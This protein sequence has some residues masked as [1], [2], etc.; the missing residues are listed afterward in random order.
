MTQLPLPQEVK[1]VYIA[2]KMSGLPLWNFPAFEEAAKN[3]RGRGLEVFSPAEH[4]LEMGFEPTRETF[5]AKERAESMHWDFETIFNVD[6]VV[7]L[8]GWE[9]GRG[10]TAEVALAWFLDKPVLSY[11]TLER[12]VRSSGEVVNGISM[13]TIMPPTYVDGIAQPDSVLQEAQRII[14]GARRKDYGPAE[15]GFIKMA[16]GWSVILGQEVTSTQV[17]LCMTW[18]KVCRFL[19]SKDRDSLVDLAGYTGLAAQIEGID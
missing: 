17:A 14:H 4:D 9:K 16:T 7:V 13:G 18:L 6:A 11:P 15:E 5:S 12:I 8:P 3:L 2:G 1:S 10:A 19:N